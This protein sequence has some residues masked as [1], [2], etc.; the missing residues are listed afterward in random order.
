M[1]AINKLPTTAIA[2]YLSVFKIHYS[3]LLAMALINLNPLHYHRF[4]PN[5]RPLVFYANIHDK[6]LRK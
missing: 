1:S 6:L 5:L 2:K 4:L 3:N